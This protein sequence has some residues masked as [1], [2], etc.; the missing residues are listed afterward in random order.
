MD[1]FDPRRFQQPTPSAPQPQAPHDHGVPVPQQP[2]AWQQ[3]PDQ[4]YP[5][6]SYPGQ[7]WPSG[8]QGPQPDGREVQ[9]WRRIAA[10][11]IDHSIKTMLTAPAAL[12]VGLLIKASLADA[13][14]PATA[15]LLI[16]L[17][18]VLILIL[19]LVQMVLL[20]RRGST[21]GQRA[22]GYSLMDESTEDPIGFWRAAGYQLL[23]YVGGSG[24]V[25][26][27]FFVGGFLLMGLAL[28]LNAEPRRR[29]LVDQVVTARALIVRPEARYITKAVVVLVAAI[30]LCVVAFAVPVLIGVSHR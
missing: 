1:P 8:P 17:S 3:Y 7:P 5:G 29:S 30:V 12:G 23:M 22:A 27:S 9:V 19:G 25:I 26:G 18:L 24:A 13:D 4:S 14:A 28:M 20:G 2:W 6:Q 11:I 10:F 16:P 21:I 15:V